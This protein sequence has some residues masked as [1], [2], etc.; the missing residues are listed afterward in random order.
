MLL[1]DAA[2]AAAARAKQLPGSIGP[3]PVRYISCRGAR[4]LHV[5]V[6]SWSR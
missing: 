2:A 1:K 3:M 5:C 4:L 6:D